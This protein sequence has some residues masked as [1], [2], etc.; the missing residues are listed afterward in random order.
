MTEESQIKK[1]F[2]LYLSEVGGS[3]DSLELEKEMEEYL[4][5]IFS[6]LERSNISKAILSLV[7]DGF[8]LIDGQMIIRLTTKGQK[9]V[10]RI[11]K[12]SM[13]F[14]SYRKVKSSDFG[15]N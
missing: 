7:Y 6:G 12:S 1:V 9:E 14:Q 8:V 2:L 11:D 10:D 4:K 13:D 3:I 15:K 5:G